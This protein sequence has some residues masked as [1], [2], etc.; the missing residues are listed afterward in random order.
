M[1]PSSVASLIH[2][3]NR[4]KVGQ[5][6]QEAGGMQS[7]GKSVAADSN[8]YSYFILANIYYDSLALCNSTVAHL[9]PRH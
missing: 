2:R 9:T 1:L 5:P 8:P 4:D 6:T 7:Q 3:Q